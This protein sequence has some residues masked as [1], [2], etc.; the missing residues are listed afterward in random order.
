MEMPGPA[1]SEGER[2]SSNPAIRVRFPKQMNISFSPWQKNMRDP[3]L[4]ETFFQRNTNNAIYWTIVN[5]LQ[6]YLWCKRER[7]SKNWSYDVTNLEGEHDV[8]YTL[9][10]YSTITTDTATYYNTSSQT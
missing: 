4:F 7:S 2:P 1:S 10:R 5:G 6:L 9:L 3:D 8:I